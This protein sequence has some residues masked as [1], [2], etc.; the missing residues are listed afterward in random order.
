VGETD[1]LDSST[2]NSTSSRAATKRTLFSHLLSAA[3]HGR[4][5]D[6]IVRMG[7]RRLLEA[8]LRDLAKNRNPNKLADFVRA[9]HHQ[10]IAVVPAK[11]NDQH[12]EI[13]SAFFQ[14]VLGPKLKYSCGHWSDSV[15]SL[16][17]AE[18]E[19][20]KI[21]CQNAGLQDG[22]DILELG[23]GW[24]SLSLWMAKQFPQSRITSVSNSHSQR[25]FIEQAA[26]SGGLSNLTV[27]TSDMNDFE[28]EHSFDRVV[29]IEMFEHM[30]NHRKLMN[31][32]AGWL[33]PDGKL[34]VH[35]FTHKDS[36]YLFRTD[37]EHNWM[38]RYFFTGGMMPS[39]DLL[40]ECGSSL[41]LANQWQWNGEHYAKTCRAWLRKQD[42]AK[43]T[44]M[45][46]LGETYGSD[47]AVV[48]HNRWRM[49]FMACEEL[50]AFNHGKE[51]FVSH[52]LFE[53]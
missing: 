11:A 33:K 30:R 19:A 20:L 39:V 23:C 47:Q 46:V 21:T 52:Y 49:F 3:E 31:N 34:F 18:T 9:T 26:E 53:K 8:G 24:G 38:G 41:K 5:P 37:G 27:I 14:Q 50:F 40:P 25:K 29:S 22:M 36:P 12:Y 16:E 43:R 4:L 2:E 51:W 13:P 7:I 17:E 42:A 35:I 15:N 6:M 1:A 32:I 10:P 28:T 45:Q 44:V 48:W